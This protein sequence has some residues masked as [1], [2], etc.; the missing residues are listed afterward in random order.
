MTYLSMTR[1]DTQTFTLTLVDGSG[2]PL[3]LTDV[4]LTFTA[5][6]RYSDSDDDA[7]IRKTVDDGIVVDEDPTTG[8][9]TVTIDPPDTSS[10]TARS[11]VWDI[12][13]D[14]GDVRTP[15]SGRLAIQPDVTRTVEGS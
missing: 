4:A 3:D 14:D 7:V 11:L 9:A 1:G 15:L 13:V 6:R 8:L 10:L 12:Q 2:D 5:K